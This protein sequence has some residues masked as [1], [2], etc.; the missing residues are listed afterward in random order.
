MSKEV[1][2]YSYWRSSSAWRV[3]VALET[4]GIKYQ[5]KAVPLLKN[6]QKSDEYSKLN[7]MQQ[8]PCLVVSEEGKADV[9]INQSLAIIEFIDSQ[10]EGPS[11]YPTDAADRAF[12]VE[13]ALDVAAGIQPIQNLVVL[14]NIEEIAGAEQ[15]T[16]WAKKWISKGLDALEAKAQARLATHPSAVYL[17]G[18][19][20]TVADACLIPQLYNARRFNVDLSVYPRL[21]AV[22]TALEAVPAFAAA[23]PDKQ[24]D[25]VL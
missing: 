2:L 9:V 7:P 10:F 25:A 5:Y 15:K 13:V 14:Q 18:A 22:E 1:T 19:E 3:R 4:K 6:E 23:H 20:P 21:L 8:V 11:L 24:P 17:V 16:A 12:A